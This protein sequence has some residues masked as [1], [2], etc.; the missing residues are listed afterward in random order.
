MDPRASVGEAPA[1]LPKVL[2]EVRGDHYKGRG[3]RQNRD[4]GLGWRLRTGHGMPAPGVCVGPLVCKSTR[5]RRAVFPLPLVATLTLTTFKDLDLCDPLLKALD[6]VGYVTPTPIQSQAIPLLLDGF[7]LLGCAQTGTGKTAAF[8]L[9][10]LE[11]LLEDPIPKGTRPI[12]VL[13][14]AP[15]RELAAQ[16]E[17]SVARYAAH[18]PLRHTV[19]FGGVPQGAQERALRQG[20]DILVATPGRLLDLIGQGIVKLGEVEF[21]VLDE[22][23]RM[24]DM[25]FIHDIKKLL[26]LLPEERQTLLFSAT[27]PKEIVEL[28]KSMLFEPKRVDITP[29]SPAVE[30]IEQSVMFMS[31]SDKRR[32]LVHL[33]EEL[34]V[35]Q[36][37]VFSRTKHGANRIVKHLAQAGVEAV[38][39]HGN[40][41]QGAR[42]R[43]LT[44]FRDGQVQVLVATDIAA[45]GIDVDTISHVINFDLPNESETYVHRIGRTAR[46][47]REGVA[48]S[49]CEETEGGYLRAIE[50]LVG[51]DI[52]M[53]KD[54]PWHDP[55]AIPAPD[56]KPP[57]GP[58]GG[59]GRGGGG[60]GGRGGRSGRKTQDNTRSSGPKPSRNAR[61]SQ[62][63]RRSNKNSR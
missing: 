53:D 45:R 18:T 54:H 48:I 29:K 21:F 46:A 55:T 57:K 50:K 42:K 37:I 63:S 23:D 9:P 10:I 15:T 26:K 52:D 47:G 43:A 59:G 17:A 4:E 11:L 41:S 34:D 19:I 49:F 39:I 2:S 30:R 35:E 40:K 28:S 60:G 14:L 61:K 1:F 31:K 38:A 62:N 56:A 7:D 32:A 3:G 51:Y 24:L 6:E 36:A 44:G 16:I 20:V 22:A 33:L 12:R 13:M 5:P 8:T 27:I 25:G 58:R